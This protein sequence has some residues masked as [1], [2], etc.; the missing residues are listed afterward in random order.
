LKY[1]QKSLLFKTLA[2]AI[3]GIARSQKP[4][5]NP[6]TFEFTATTSALLK[7]VFYKVE[8]FYFVLK[9]H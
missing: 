9:T 2:C 8:G 6:S 5:A 7:S 1:G 3:W 4:G